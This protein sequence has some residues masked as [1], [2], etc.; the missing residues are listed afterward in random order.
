MWAWVW[1]LGPPKKKGGTI[2]VRLKYVWLHWGTIWH[3][4]HCAVSSERLL[5]SWSHCFQCEG[6]HATLLLLCSG[7]PPS[8]TSLLALSNL[9]IK[10]PSRS[11][12]TAFS[13]AS[14]PVPSTKQKTRTQS[15]QRTKYCLEWS[16]CPNSL[17]SHN[18][19]SRESSNAFL[20]NEGTNRTQKAK[21]LGLKL[22]TRQGH[23]ALQSQSWYSNPGSR[24][25]EPRLLTN[26]SPFHSYQ[27]GGYS[28]CSWLS[29]VLYFICLIISTH[30]T[31]YNTSFKDS[32][33][34]TF[35]SW[36]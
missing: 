20:I 1:A 10:S 18:M 11:I 9:Q 4:L 27:A 2:S 31:H 21:L 5:G 34:Q 23:T 3:E 8:V 19:W 35:P 12:T 16:T 30:W 14:F 28:P 36:M 25:L 15:L 26:A 33:K 22:V 6:L 24:A 7:S 17:N 13:I 29:L 32:S